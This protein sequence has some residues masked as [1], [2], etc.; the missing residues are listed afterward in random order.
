MLPIRT[1][2]PP[3]TSSSQSNDG[4]PN[5]VDRINRLRRL[6]A[7]ARP[8]VDEENPMLDPTRAEDRGGQRPAG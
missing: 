7:A 6:I 4:A 8:L 3:I 2:N 5:L 1:Q